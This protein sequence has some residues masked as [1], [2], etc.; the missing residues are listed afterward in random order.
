MSTA[1]ALDEPALLL[2]ARQGDEGAYRS[3]VQH[4]QGELHAHCYRML[5]SVHDADDAVQD[6]MVSA[7]KGLANFEARSSVRT[8]LFKIATNAALDISRRRQRREIPLG[9]GQ[10]DMSSDGPGEPAPGIQWVEP[11]PDSPELHYEARETL[12]LAYVALLQELPAHQRAVFILREA[13]NLPAAEVAVVLD[14]SVAAVNSSLQRARSKIAQRVPSVSQQFELSV[15]GDGGTRALAERYARAIED[16]DV[17]SLLALL[18]EDPTWSMPPHPGWF[19]GRSAI[20]AFLREDVMINQWRHIPACVSG[21]LAVAGYVFDPATEYYLA[22][23]LDVL[24]LEHGR[25]RAVLSFLTAIG[26]PPEDN[27]EPSGV[28]VINFV[29][30]GLPER[31]PAS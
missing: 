17:E 8:W 5:A 22:C 14:T 18:V 29:R 16:G 11:Y 27:N 15:L 19:A 2:A 7:W 31:L 20:A 30:F 4:H 23:A 13:L 9:Y 3:L 10:R 21:Q 1:T 6:V 28:G 12:E 26:F 24:A 25:I